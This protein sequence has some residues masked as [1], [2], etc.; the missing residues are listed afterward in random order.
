[1]IENKNIKVL[2]VDDEVLIAETLKDLL[3]RLNFEQIK[4]AHS[5]DETFKL[6][7]LWTPDMAILDIRMVELYDGLELGEYLRNELKIPFMYVTA[8]S[9]M[10]MTQRIMKTKP[11]GYIT[12]PIRLNE[13]MINVSMVTARLNEIRENQVIEFK[14]G[15]EIERVGL[16]DLNFIKS[17]SNYLEV[18]TNQKKYVLRNT[19]EAFLSE[20]NNE[21]I[22]RVHRSFAV[23]RLKIKKYSRT[24][25]EVCDA[26][27][28]I[29]RSYLDEFRLKK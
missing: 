12:K 20:I 14:N 23:N 25:I 2:I 13:L 10:E 24:E 26:Q 19:M 3:Q 1:M 28:P 11:D 29:S 17:E 9:D 22:V 7:K 6:L 27:I 16:S 21:N 15:V 4:L 5:K 8:H 18:Y